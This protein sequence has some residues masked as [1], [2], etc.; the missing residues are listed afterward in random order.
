MGSFLKGSLSFKGKTEHVKSSTSH[1]VVSLQADRQGRALPGAAPLL[2]EAG[3]RDTQTLPPD[4]TRLSGE[5]LEL[6]TRSGEAPRVGGDPGGGGSYFPINVCQ[7][8]PRDF[9]KCQGR[10]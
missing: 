6:L 1:P 8:I 2:G 3:L 10:L 4:S 7:G 5:C 9:L